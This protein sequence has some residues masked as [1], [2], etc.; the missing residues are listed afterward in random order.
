MLGAEE[1][2]QRQPRKMRGREGE[3][4]NEDM[5]PEQAQEP[6]REQPQTPPEESTVDKINKFRGLFGY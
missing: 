5:P 3:Q 6:R 2:Q 1:H 4:Y